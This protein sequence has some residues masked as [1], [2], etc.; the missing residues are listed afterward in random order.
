MKFNLQITFN[1]TNDLID[2]ILH[3]NGIDNN[4]SNHL[5]IPRSYYKAFVSALLATGQQMQTDNIDVGFTDEDGENN[6]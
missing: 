1:P 5:V 2:I 3:S 6:D 4:T